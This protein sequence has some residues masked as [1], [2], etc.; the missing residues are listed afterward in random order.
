MITL[1]RI[2]SH[3]DSSSWRRRGRK[4]DPDFDEGQATDFNELFQAV[5]EN[6]EISWSH[7]R[8][9]FAKQHEHPGKKSKLDLSV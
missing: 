3:V 7:N 5:S 1:N 6:S 8:K 9:P 4:Y 2:P